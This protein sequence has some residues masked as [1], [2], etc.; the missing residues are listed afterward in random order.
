MIINLVLFTVLMFSGHLWLRIVSH[1]YVRR[2]VPEVIEGLLLIIYGVVFA[3]INRFSFTHLG[4][5]IMFLYLMFMARILF[6]I[7]TLNVLTISFLPVVSFYTIRGFLAATT[8]MIWQKTTFFVLSYPLTRWTIFLA[9]YSILAILTYA[10]SQVL[11][12]NMNIKM[13]LRNTM[14]LKHILRIELIMMVYLL[15]VNDGRF[16]DNEIHWFNLLYASASVFIFVI[17]SVSW[18]DAIRGASLL[19]NARYTAKVE[20]Q[21]KMQV[22]HY[23]SYQDLLEEYKK[24]KHDYRAMLQTIQHL[25]AEEQIVGA[26]NI[27]QQ[28]HDSFQETQALEPY[29]QSHLLDAI[30]KD[31]KVRCDDLEINYQLDLQLPDTFKLTELNMLRVLTNIINNA[32]EASLPIS[33]PCDRWIKIRSRVNHRWLSLEVT[34]QYVTEPIYK[35]GQYLSTKDSPDIHG[36]GLQ[37]VREIVEKSEGILKI[38]TDLV[39]RQFLVNIT[40]PY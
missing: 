5:F 34:N 23:E 26:K 38:K 33:N 36:I 39:L 18:N 9:S 15:I 21:L 10:L 2:A 7:P 13:F 14:K 16:L 27:I 4:P 32:I 40:I 30:I 37:I 29:S 11:D 22:Q 20:N 31:F 19:E 6:I 1:Y 24:F 35:H 25:I 8:A 3:L 28:S 12:V 17:L